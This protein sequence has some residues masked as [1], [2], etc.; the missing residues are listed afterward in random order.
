MAALIR[1]YRFDGPPPPSPDDPSLGDRFGIEDLLPPN[2]ACAFDGA[3]DIRTVFD[4][5]LPG[6]QWNERGNGFFR[7]GG[8]QIQI[9]MPSRDQPYISLSI[10][11]YGAAAQVLR[12]VESDRPDWYT[13]WFDG[14]WLRD[15]PVP[16]GG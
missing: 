5:H 16:E 12:A 11:D 8:F 3:E 7:R 9:L 14:K 15:T 1:I 6:I 4:R 10:D 13:E 2:P